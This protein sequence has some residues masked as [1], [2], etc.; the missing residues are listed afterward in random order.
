MTSQEEEQQQPISTKTQIKQNKYNFDLSYLNTKPRET[1]VDSMGN[2]NFSDTILENQIKKALLLNSSQSVTTTIADTITILD[3]AG[4]RSD[5][6]SEK[7]KSVDGL[8]YFK[9]LRSLTI[10]YNSISDL[11]PLEKL[12]NLE[13]LVA[14]NNIIKEITP[15]KDL[16]KLKLLN[17]Y[18]N[19]V[20]DISALSNLTNLTVLRLWDNNVSTIQTLSK[21]TNLKE[22][23]LGQNRIKDISPLTNCKKLHTIWLAFNPIVNPELLSEFNETLRVLSISGCNIENIDYLENCYKMKDL[24]IFSNQIEDISVIR[25]MTSLKS[26]IAYN[27]QI[28]SIDVVPHLIKEG[29]FQERSRFG[30]SGINIDLKNN[31]INFETEKNKRIK[32]YI[33]ENVRGVKF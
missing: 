18:R 14:E 21:L 17:L 24:L 19:N 20:S 29:A 6:F 32:T 11:T 9:S 26:L 3:I 15:L 4:N 8:Q 7:I 12:V 22:I 10:S 33:E 31:P 16:T 28:E 25:K 27:N 2:I 23:N 30:G 13:K 5:K 1:F